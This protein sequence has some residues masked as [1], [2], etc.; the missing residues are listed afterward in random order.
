MLDS[1]IH[2]P[3]VTPPRAVIFDMDG[4]MFNTEDVY[5]EVGSQLMRRRG[6]EYTSEL[7][8]A[9]MGRSP[10]VC[11]ETMIRWHSLNDDGLGCSRHV[12]G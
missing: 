4:L 11:F 3:I 2:R 10:R 5:F 1:C 9:V 7:N 8:D 6:C 12:A